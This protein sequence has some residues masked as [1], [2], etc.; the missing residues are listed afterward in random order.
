MEGVMADRVP[1]SITIGGHADQS[2]FAEL[3]ALIAMEGLSTEWDGPSFEPGHRT[4]GEAVSLH[5]HE[6]AWGRV[7]ALES[8]CAE[9]GLPFV[10][11]SGSYPGEW[12]AER[13]VFRGAGTIDSYMVDESDRVMI[14][15][16]LVN[17]RGSIAAV[18]AYFDA[19]AFVVPPLVVEGDPPPVDAA[20]VEEACHG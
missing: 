14:D 5:A 4:I 15:R 16:Y 8:F 10:R 3:A 17:E 18:L 2:T 13:I 6:V 11:W 9:K 1:V 7:E 20:A 12:S 19:A